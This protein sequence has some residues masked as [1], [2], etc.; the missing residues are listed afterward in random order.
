MHA[1]TSLLAVVRMVRGSGVEDY[2]LDAKHTE[3]T[4]EICIKL[5]LRKPIVDVVDHNPQFLE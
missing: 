5:V 3:Q 1:M 2:K 4:L